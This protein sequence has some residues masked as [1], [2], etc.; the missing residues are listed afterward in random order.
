MDSPNTQR[1]TIAPESLPETNTV[2]ASCE[3][4]PPL[5]DSFGRVHESLRVSVTDAC[6]I[7]CR[8]CMPE[9]VASFLPQH[10]LLSFD[11]IARVVSVLARSGIRKVRL[12]GGE[13]L[14]RPNLERLV[15]KLAKIQ[16]LAQI[17]MTTNAMLLSDRVSALESAGLTHINIS[18]DTLREAAFKRISRRDGLDAV[19]RGIESAVATKLVVRLNALLMRDINLQDC[20]P[21]VEFAR[22]KNLFI[23]FIEFMPLDADRQWSQDQVVSG[24][25]LRSVL[26]SH[27]GS[28]TSIGRSDPAQPS[29]D[30]G[31]Q[32]GR[33]GVGFI[34]PVSQPFCQ[35]C[36]RVRLTAD[37]KLRNCLFSQEEWDL[38]AA[39]E[40]NASDH[41]IYSIATA[42]IRKK[43]ASHGIS[44]S[45][46][47]QPERAMYQIGG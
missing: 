10:R 41:E 30:F 46:F 32:D 15:D 14:M 45:N 23:R 19:L 4:L 31:F 3:P 9:T 38:K 39:C 6:N 2:K 22:T 13:P 47:K 40:S 18:L 12:T 17:A 42:C 29:S 36:N 27:F 24:T 33:G 26:E 28:L 34:D 11:S 7:R 25:E 37:G 16:G 43:Y 35:S 20:I 8:Y 5:I 44:E 1:M 21:L